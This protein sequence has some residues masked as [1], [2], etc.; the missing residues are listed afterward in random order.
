ML[1]L[2][3]LVFLA[4]TA[5]SALNPP[6]PTPTATPTWTPSP[7]HTVTPSITPTPTFTPSV[8]PTP[9][10]TFTPTITPTNTP[11]PTPSNTP[12]PTVGF[13]GYQ[14]WETVSRPNN[15]TQVLSGPALAFLNTNNRDTV[16]DSRT[17]QPATN[18]QA[19]YYVAGSGGT[20][21]QIMQMSAATGN[22]VWVS[23]TGTAFAYIRVDNNPDIAGLYVVDLDLQI[24]GRILPISS[25]IQR[26]F[27]SPPSWSPD[28][29][30]LAIAL[31]TSYAIDIFTVGR[32]GLNPMNITQSGSYDFWPVW[33]PDGRYI[34][35]VSDREMCPT[36]VPGEPDTC[37]SDNVQPP[38]GGHAYIIDV[39]SN[40]VVRIS[41][42]WVTEPPRW[43]TPRQIVYA[44]GDPLFGD[45]ERTIWIADIFTRENRQLVLADGRDPIKLS[46]AWSPTGQL[47]LYQAAGTTTEIVLARID[48][49]EIARTSDLIFTRYGMT[50]AWSPDGGSIAIGGVNGQC[51][52]GIILTDDSLTFRV[53]G[54]PPPSMCEPRFSPDGRFLAF[55]GVTPNVDGRVDVWIANSNGFGGRNVTANLRGQIELLGWIGGQ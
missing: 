27:Y 46:E 42:E 26:G 8:T 48:G 18:V 20:P 3:M 25:V 9:T 11:T 43:L 2:L 32:D 12:M 47:V 36:W 19:L 23:P 17:P 33:S 16:G 39:T 21:L 54:S 51:P 31:T 52:Y 24:S 34:L 40:Q 45:S 38:T 6:T 7:T 22:Q 37:D 4:T 13:V 49:T 53:R 44:S 30:R 29:T 35:F 1:K 10:L 41:D 28:G 15:L 5:C 50:A 55:T 14:N